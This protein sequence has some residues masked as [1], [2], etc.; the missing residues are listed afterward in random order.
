MRNAQ[1]GTD[2]ACFSSIGLPVRKFA[3]DTRMTC[4]NGKFHGMTANSG[5]RGSNCCRVSL[6]SDSSGRGRSA[7]SPVSA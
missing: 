1:R 7:R 6:P 3:A 4:Q 5:P 2:G